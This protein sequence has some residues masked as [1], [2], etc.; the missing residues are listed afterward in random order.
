MTQSIKKVKWS[1]FISLIFIFI[2]LY[3]YFIQIPKY[4]TEKIVNQ[5]ETSIRNN[6]KKTLNKI[7]YEQS[8]FFEQIDISK[9]QK[10]FRKFEEGIEI[11]SCTFRP[12][13]LSNSDEGSI[14]AQG[15]M[16][17]KIDGKFRNYF[18][19]GLIKK[20]KRWKLELFYF[21]DFIDY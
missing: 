1:F 19:I 20:N 4:Q 15:R 21:P 3:L 17:A 11:Y 8:K 13:I 18:E 9:W 7:I 12:G 10:E 5:F 14:H 2:F 6:D 16:I